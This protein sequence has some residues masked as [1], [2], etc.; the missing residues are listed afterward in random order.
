MLKK[1][2]VI[3][4]LL[5]GSLL[6]VTGASTPDKDKPVIAIVTVNNS[7]LEDSSYIV[8][9]TIEHLKS[10]FLGQAVILEGGDL[11]D[12]LKSAGIT[13]ISNADS[14]KLTS[15]LKELGV[16]YLVRAEIGKVEIKRGIKMG[17]VIKKWCSADLLANITVNDV[18]NDKILYNKTIAEKGKNEVSLGFASS[19]GAVKIALGKVFEQFDNE[20]NLSNK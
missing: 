16:T 7:G 17:L 8:D 13:D 11:S 1:I 4:F 12:K 18:I 19:A 6:S 10:K 2:I 3:T 15:A 9:N 5:V 20:F 14:D